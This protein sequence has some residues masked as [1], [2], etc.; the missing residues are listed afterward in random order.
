MA[1]LPT[2]LGR[3][4]GAM[5]P[6]LLRRSFRDLA[7]RL[8]EVAERFYALLFERRP[9]VR[10]LFARTS[11]E[12]QREKLVASL[13][14]CVG[15]LGRD[16]DL[17]AMLGEL[18]HAHVGYGTLPE[19]YPPVVDALVDALGEVAGEAWSPALETTWR[20]VLEEVSTRMQSGSPPG[21]TV[22]GSNFPPFPR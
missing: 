9:D 20:A 11:P 3:H 5:D 4:A 19:H 12:V 6:D 14:L 21:K 16:E 18:G 2:T 1:F 15:L 17:D 10:P 7:P 22:P 8:D 13:A